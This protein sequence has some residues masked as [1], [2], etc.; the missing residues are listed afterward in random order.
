MLISLIVNDLN[1]FIKSYGSLL[2]N[3]IKLLLLKVM[4][5]FFI[6]M[7]WHMRNHVRF[8]VKID[9]SKT[10][11]TIK[12]FSC[13]VCNSSKSFMK[14]DMILILVMAKSFI[15]FLLDESFLLQVGLKLILMV[16]QRLS[17]SCCLWWY[18]SW[19]YWGVYWWFL[20]FL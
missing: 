14:N 15:I 18:F 16:R 8:Q 10:I 13:L 1:S 12:D 7:I 19:E 4:I 20:C 6:W 9:L 11:S 2:I 5:S 3:L 17:W